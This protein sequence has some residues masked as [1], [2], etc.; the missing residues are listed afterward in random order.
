MFEKKGSLEPGGIS[1]KYSGMSRTENNDQHSLDTLNASK[2]SFLKQK[3]GYRGR[4][5]N[6]DKRARRW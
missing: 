5:L 2:D 6:D 1:E 3:A 4:K